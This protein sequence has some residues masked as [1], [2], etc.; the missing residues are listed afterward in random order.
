MSSLVTASSDD[1]A[2]VHA[3]TTRVSH[4]LVEELI[5][6][7]PKGESVGLRAVVRKHMSH[8][9]KQACWAQSV[10]LSKRLSYDFEGEVSG[11]GCV[12]R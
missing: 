10:P 8:A 5:H 2:S 6:D 3:V 12:G 7:D 9:S 4:S 1:D 11:C